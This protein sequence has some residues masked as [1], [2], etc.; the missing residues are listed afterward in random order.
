MIEINVPYLENEEISDYARKFLVG[1]EI[2]SVPVDIE[3]IVEFKYGMDIVPTPGL[4]K[5]ID[6][7]GFITSDFSAIY[8][9]DYVY[10]QV[11]NRYRFTLAHEIGHFFMHGEILSRF[12]FDSIEG[13]KSF[14]YELDPRDH[15]KMEFQAYAFAGQVLVPTKKLK[16]E[17]YKLK[18]NFEQLVAQAQEQG[19]KKKTY[20]PYAIENI[21][22]I[23]SPI[24]EVS[25]A[26]IKRRVAF[27]GLE[28]IIT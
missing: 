1:H 25:I 19:I 26:V 7:D 8:V 4:R 16:E 13:W 15:S 23:L 5:L 3:K 10:S 22:Q 11:P 28:K 24:F 18:P 20:L 12:N 9:D 6:M 2:D 14:V 21:A 27:D 17:F